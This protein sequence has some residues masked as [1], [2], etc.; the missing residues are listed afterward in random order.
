MLILAYCW[1]YSRRDRCN[2]TPLHFFCNPSVVPDS[3]FFCEVG[4]RYS[5]VQRVFWLLSGVGFGVVGWRGRGV[6]MYSWGPHLKCFS[7]TSSSHLG[8]C[9]LIQCASTQDPRKQRCVACTKVMVTLLLTYPHVF[10]QGCRHL[11][12]RRLAILF[13][14]AVA[15]T[16]SSPSTEATKGDRCRRCWRQA[17]RYILFSPLSASW[18]H[19]YSDQR[20]Y[21]RASAFTT[22]MS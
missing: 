1:Y 18:R 17:S 8:C 7:P 4:F 15:S 14:V 10:E 19:F 3:A 9:T 20:T 6:C 21:D 13:R 12:A 11:V 2:L 5:M 22:R 16:P